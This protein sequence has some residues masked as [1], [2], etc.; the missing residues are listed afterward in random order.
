M[1]EGRTFKKKFGFY[2][3]KDYNP[4]G[5]PGGGAPNRTGSGRISTSLHADPSIRFNTEAGELSVEKVIR[6][7]N[8]D[9]EKYRNDLGE[10]IC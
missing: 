3:P 6:Y 9:K 5:K 1:S 8:Q 10:Y 7:R 4:F 2:L